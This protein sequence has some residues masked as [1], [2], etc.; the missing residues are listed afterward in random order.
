MFVKGRSIQALLDSGSWLSIASLKLVQSLHIPM[1]STPE[2]YCILKSAG[3]DF[4]NVCGKATLDLSINHLSMCHEFVIVKNLTLNVLLGCDFMYKCNVAIDFV[5]RSA[6]FMGSLT[7]AK[8]LNQSSE[9]SETVRTV[10]SIILKPYTETVVHISLLKAYR[11]AD[12]V[13]LEPMTCLENQQFWT[14]RVVV[15]PTGRTTACKICNPTAETIVLKP[16][17]PLA[18]VEKVNVNAISVMEG[19]PETISRSPEER[20]VEWSRLEQIDV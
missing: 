14:A 4:L 18:T 11:G 16:W 8:L 2:E 15:H 1:K 7:A 5:N 6:S 19:V 20:K 12:A 3:D 10:N 13:V 17:V 9:L